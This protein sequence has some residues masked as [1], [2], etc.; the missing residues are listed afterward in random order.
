[1]YIAPGI[2]SDK[3]KSLDLADAPS[4]DWQVAIGYL[5][6][7][8]T[9]RYLDPV[10]VLIESEKDVTPAKKKL[11]FTILAIDCLLVE[12]FQAFKDH[13]VII[14]GRINT[15][16]KSKALFKDFLTTSPSFSTHFTEALAIKFYE[17]FRCGIL[18]VA[19]IQGD[20]RVWSVGPLVRTE[21]NGLKIN[22]TKFHEFIKKDFSLYIDDLKTNRTPALR[23]T[24]RRVM[25]AICRV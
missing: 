14:N 11:G 9:S 8:I 12:T 6:Q 17:E 16:N 23:D 2:H 15:T 3:Y 10:D 5:H 20:S 1:M 25:D 24:F 7:R 13:R 4:P 21:G 18:H 22:R 19:E